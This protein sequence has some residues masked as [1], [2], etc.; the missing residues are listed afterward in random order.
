ME[1]LQ[2]ITELLLYESLSAMHTRGDVFVLALS[3]VK[4]PQQI[5]RLAMNY[6]NN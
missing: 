4:T 1:D 5:I 2:H 6:Q 3:K